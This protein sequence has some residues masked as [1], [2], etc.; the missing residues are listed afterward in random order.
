MSSP[1]HDPISN[2]WIEFMSVWFQVGNLNR[3]SL[4]EK[5]LI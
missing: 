2:V 5:I 4:E 1:I 3:F